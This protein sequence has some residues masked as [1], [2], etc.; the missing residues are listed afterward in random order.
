MK[1]LNKAVS[2][3]LALLMA[4]S[5]FASG[6]TVVFAEDGLATQNTENSIVD[7]IPEEPTDEIPEE[8]TDEIP[9]EPTDEMP[10]E[11]TDEIPE[12]PTD[13]NIEAESD[14]LII[15]VSGISETKSFTPENCNYTFEYFIQTDTNGT[16]VQI[17][18]FS[19]DATGDIDVVVPEKIED[20]VVDSI[21]NYTFMLDSD[22]TYTIKSIVLPDSIINIGCSAFRGC[23]FETIV[24]PK[25]TISI[26]MQAFYC[27]RNLKSI[28]I[29]D[30]VT[31]VYYAA[32]EG[33]SSLTAIELPSSVKTIGERAF[34]SCS[35]LN[36][37][38]IPE[39]VTEI[40]ALAFAD[41]SSLSSAI[42]IPEKVKVINANAFSGCSRL[43]SVTLPSE[44]T[45][46]GSD[47]FSYSSV[48][49]LVIPNSVTAIGENAFKYCGL[50]SVTLPSGLTRI[51]N[52]VFYGASSLQTVTMG[53][54][55]N[56]IGDKAFY[57]CQSLK[58][59]TVPSSLQSIGKNTFQN[60]R[61]ESV[62]YAEGT[63][64]IIPSMFS[65]AKI[66]SVTFPKSLK[67][68]GSKAFAY[69]D[70]TAVVIPEGVTEIGSE[71]FSNCKLKSITIPATV[72][73]IG[74]SA[75]ES[76]G[77]TAC[78]LPE[79]VEVIGDSAFSNCTGVTA[80]TI[81]SSVKSL[82]A[83]AFGSCFKL[84]SVKIKEGLTVIGK[85]AFGDC[86]ALTSIQLPSSVTIIDDYAF[87][88]DTSLP[89]IT[90]P[91]NVEH[92]GKEAFENCEKLQKV[93]FPDKL[94]TVGENAFLNCDSLRSVTLG[95]SMSNIDGM[96]GTL[97]KVDV[98]IG[99]N[100]KNFVWYEGV[101]YTSDYEEAVFCPRSKTGTI[102]FHPNIKKIGDLCFERCTKLAKSIVIP[103]SVEEIGELAFAYSYLKGGTL[104]LGDKTTVIGFAA[105]A[106]NGF[107]GDLYF[108]EGTEEIAECGFL[109]AGFTG[110]LHLPESLRLI[111]ARAF[112]V[113]GFKG[114]LIIPDSVV[115]IGGSAFEQS[116][117]TGDLILPNNM[118]VLNDK[119]FSNCEGLNGYVYTGDN[120]KYIEEGVFL[121]CTNIKLIEVSS[122]VE[123]VSCNVCQGC[124]SSVKLVIPQGV[125]YND[126]FFNQFSDY[127]G[128]PVL[129]RFA[130]KER[131][132]AAGDS[133]SSNAE[134]LPKCTVEKD[135]IWTSSDSSIASVDEDGIVTGIGAGTVEIT[136]VAAEGLT[137]SYT[138]TVKQ[139]LTIEMLNFSEE[140]SFVYTGS[141][142]TPELTLTGLIS[143]TDYAVEYSS[144]INVG[145]GKAVVMGI[146]NY[147]GTL[148]KEFTIVPKTLSDDMF[149]AVSEKYLFD[150]HPMDPFKISYNGYTLVK[151]TDYT[152]T[153]EDEGDTEIGVK[154]AEIAGL[155]NYSGS[156]TK[157]F[158]IVKYSIDASMVAAIPAQDYIVGHGEVEPPIIIAYSGIKLEKDRDYTVEYT[159]NTGAGTATATITGIGNYTGVITV[160]FKINTRTLSKTMPQAIAEL[161]Y[162]GA[163]LT[164]VVV[165]DGETTLTPYDAAN[166]SN[167]NADYKVTY[168][169]NINK[170]TAT[171]T[172]KGI[173]SYKGTVTVTFKIVAKELPANAIGTIENAVYKGSQI[174]PTL[175][176]KDGE[177]LLKLNKDYTVKYTN[178]VNAGTATATITGKGNYKGTVS[179]DFTIEPKVAVLTVSSIVAQT[180]SG[181]RLTPAVTVKDGR[182]TLKAGVDYIVEYSENLNVGTAIVTVAGAGNYLGSAPTEAASFT[183]KPVSISKATIVVPS[184]I[185]NNPENADDNK[186]AP[187]ITFAR[188]T[189]I[190]NTDYTL[191]YA[192]YD[193][194]GTANVTISGAGNF[195]GTV[196]KSYKIVSGKV[197][198]DCT[199]GQLGYR[200][201]SGSQ[202][203]P[204]PVI[205][206][207]E[208][209]LIYGKDFTVSGYKNN[210]NVGTATATVTGIGEYTGTKKVTFN[211]STRTLEA[212]DVVISSISNKVYTGKEIKPSV[213]IKWNTKTLRSGTDYML[214][215]RYNID[216]GSATV[217]IYFKGN[218]YGTLTQTF[219]I[220]PYS[221][222]RLSVASISTQYYTGLEITPQ[223]VI[224]MGK[225]TLALTDDY[226][227]TYSNNT[228]IGK[229]T[230]TVIGAEGGN[231]TGSK[232]INFSIA[233]H[234]I[235]ASDV[236]VTGVTPEVTYDGTAKRQ[237]GLTLTYSGNT[238]TENTDYTVSY[239]NNVRVGKA[240]ITIRGIG[241]YTGSRTVSFTILGRDFNAVLSADTFGYN[242]K[243]QKP[244]VTATD[245]ADSTRSMRLN[246]EYSVAYKNNINAGTATVTVK[247]MGNYAGWTKTLSFSITPKTAALSVGTIKNQTYD[248]TL[249]KPSLTVKDGS[250]TLKY[251]TD[252]VTGYAYN[253]YAGTAQVTVTGIGNYSSGSIG[254]KTFKIAMPK[255]TVTGLKNE[256]GKKVTIK[257]KAMPGAGGYVIEYATDKNFTNAF[258]S[259]TV[260]D[261]IT[262]KTI[263]S[264][265]IG[266]TYYF[267]IALLDDNQT[268]AERIR[269]TYSSVLSVK[270]KK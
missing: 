104:T 75:F 78:N 147:T 68:I 261:S 6:G 121:G 133:V 91:A 138:L 131:T 58:S 46:I 106:N 169:N 178:N 194:T 220:V 30:S 73:T 196:K 92:I 36:T 167:P 57:N 241:K 112:A 110:D 118:E 38:N 45:R 89:S 157:S 156:V 245:T 72:K 96:F 55:V 203:K 214:R 179:A 153:F 77:I 8:P 107:V 225:T 115:E 159:N 60:A 146:G 141:E 152:V 175:T 224:K 23:K 134:L 79:G 149:E 249:K 98:K 19:S 190:A 14:Q 80:V 136:A 145:T 65:D 162:T 1:L 84:K 254:K 264:M 105:F 171:A 270:V 200:S 120:C 16:Y 242:G 263:E 83:H 86:Y 122:V 174:K 199:F 126:I 97:G 116:K 215:Y 170:G 172:I 236:T 148:E 125:E 227:L 25:K 127:D 109:N 42:V 262:V 114:R 144:N 228:A 95:A 41:C 158:E 176:V 207:D 209:P 244:T 129:L 88:S 59:F 100:C 143:G 219:E 35:S 197:L 139:G 22:D 9:E 99:S 243:A 74:E 166:P 87:S 230:V 64:A 111:G 189:L 183:I 20:I 234:P 193:T 267:R 102:K 163:A 181:S 135:I 21:G 235:S 71:A 70:L 246:R 28:T 198:D 208:T 258:T 165:K 90:L 253:K 251:G 238:L 56:Y 119:V 93:V 47:A 211:I 237:G 247:G 223:P 108:P 229:A 76:S 161:T 206:Y 54:S 155:G 266:T 39:N 3:T 201:Y 32:F 239:S 40:G 15:S 85:S 67:T 217:T 113:T 48:R 180:Y 233:K 187:E 94:K 248:G 2:L 53:N 5:V 101:I 31:G 168:R 269:G 43:T 195:T 62:E 11:P 191:L 213:T 256:T 24:L 103:N 231:F 184:H 124:G 140:E 268:P 142:I 12:E 205:E 188:D 164:P 34:S 226:T 182:K 44:L 123:L 10:E 202:L 218:Y 33:C 232:T 212:E 255:M 63:T 259:I 137:S 150:G 52:S 26:S 216:V 49:N 204:I 257:W 117:F 130:E 4:L 260:A 37:I 222:S 154:T 51:E 210:I 240:K 185:Q 61:I 29:P 250:K 7:E 265:D 81:P 192:K 27:C 128:L 17:S 13:E 132:I 173:N 18:G 50:V 177:T 69:C 82:G 66:G 186:A 160:N 252:Y 221:V 151:N